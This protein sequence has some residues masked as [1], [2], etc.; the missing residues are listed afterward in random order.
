MGPVGRSDR[1]GR[2]AEAGAWP[3]A[4]C[5]CGRLGAA[6]GDDAS[7]PTAPPAAPLSEDAGAGAGADAVVGVDAGGWCF[8]GEGLTGTGEC[9]GGLPCVGA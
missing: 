5:P 9:V 8:S 7:L 6:F 1:D 2:V 3:C 4:C